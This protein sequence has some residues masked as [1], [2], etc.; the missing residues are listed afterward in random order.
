MHKYTKKIGWQ[1]YEDFIEKQL[2]SPLLNTV[3]QN[4]AMQNLDLQDEEI[5]EED[6][7]DEE[8]IKDSSHL[9]MM[10]PVTRQLVEDIT[11]LLIMI[12]I[13]HLCRDSWTEL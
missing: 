13:G 11:I 9:S 12:F 5:L 4:I 3:M 2:S 8:Q 7:D 1:K 10:M 6:L